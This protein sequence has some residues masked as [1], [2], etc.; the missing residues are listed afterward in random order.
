MNDALKLATTPFTNW[1]FVFNERSAEALQG[2]V[3]ELIDEVQK[4]TGAWMQRR[5][6]AS[7]EAIRSLQSILGSKDPGALTSAYSDWLTKSM[8]IVATDMR[9]AQEQALR[10]SEIGQKLVRS[11]FQTR[12][13]AAESARPKTDARSTVHA[14]PAAG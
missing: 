7:Q 4:T 10:C 6:E 1:P 14:R 8:N 3:R 11:A 2:S 13:E 5:Q 12:S 9:D